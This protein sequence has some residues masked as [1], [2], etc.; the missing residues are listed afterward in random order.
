MLAFL[1]TYTPDETAERRS[2][3]HEF[4]RE[5]GGGVAR[6]DPSRRRASLRLLILRYRFGQHFVAKIGTQEPRR[7]QFHAAS[8]RD[9]ELFLDSE[10]LESGRRSDFE[11]NQY[12]HVAI[13]P[14]ILAQHRPE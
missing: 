6:P 5:G 7:M 8:E 14:E 4:L 10:E 9:R 3:V 2:Q 1:A 13:R 12:I 11:L